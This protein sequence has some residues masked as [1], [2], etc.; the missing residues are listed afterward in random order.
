MYFCNMDFDWLVQMFVVGF[1]QELQCNVYDCN[2]YAIEN[3][4]EKMQ[5]QLS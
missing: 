1:V 5:L 3:P 2:W 4:D